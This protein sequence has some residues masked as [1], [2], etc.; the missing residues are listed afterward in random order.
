LSTPLPDDAAWI[1]LLVPNGSSDEEVLSWAAETLPP[2]AVAEL[3]TIIEREAE[4]GD[5]E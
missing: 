3:A 2:A 1:M 4:G 5:A